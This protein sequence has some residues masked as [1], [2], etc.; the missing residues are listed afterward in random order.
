MDSYEIVLWP[1]TWVLFSTSDRLNI[2]RDLIQELQ[3]H[4]Y[5]EI[6]HLCRQ[7]FPAFWSFL[8]KEVIHQYIITIMRDWKTLGGDVLDKELLLSME[9]RVW[10][11]NEC[12]LIAPTAKLR[13]MQN[14]E[15]FIREIARERTQTSY[16][17]K[18]LEKFFLC[19]WGWREKSFFSSSTLPNR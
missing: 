19:R 17:G 3:K 9:T 8:F 2:I 4:L 1:F 16:K 6:I 10:L 15:N 18:K 7:F 14:Y 13:L 5:G 11:R 12:L